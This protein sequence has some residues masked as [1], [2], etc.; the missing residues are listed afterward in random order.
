MVAMMAATAVGVGP[1]SRG[2]RRVE[3]PRL[4]VVPSDC[5]NHAWVREGNGQR[6][7]SLL[8]RRN[9]LK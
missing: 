7:I 9:D 6:R 4:E 3:H 8:R 1:T 5:L 2:R